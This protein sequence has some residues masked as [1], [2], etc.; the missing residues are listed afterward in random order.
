MVF[1]AWP[2]HSVCIRSSVVSSVFVII[3]W[4]VLNIFFPTRS[5]DLSYPVQTYH[6]PAATLQPTPLRWRAGNEAPHRSCLY[7]SPKVTHQSG[8]GCLSLGGLLEETWG[9]GAGLPSPSHVSSHPHPP[10]SI[11]AELSSLALARAQALPNCPALAE[12][13]GPCILVCVSSCCL[14]QLAAS[15]SGR[16][17]YVFSLPPLHLMPEIGRG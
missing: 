3:T 9:S 1:T 8:C 11:A 4:V 13:V 5:W 17:G 2:R 16:A 7:R 6:P 14:P 10:T 15:G 12:G